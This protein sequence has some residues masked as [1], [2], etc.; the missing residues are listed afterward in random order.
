MIQTEQ[1]ERVVRQTFDGDVIGAYRHGSAVLGGLRSSSDID[2]LVVARRRMT[3]SERQTL[4]TGL[5]A[6]SGPGA[7]LGPA[8]PVE[9]AVIVEPDVRPWRYPPRCEFL[10]G[11]WLRAQ[12]LAG[13]IPPPDHSPELA[14]MITVALLG[15][16]RLF[17]PPPA[18]VLDPVP[19]RD[20]LRA[21][22][23]GVPGLL[24]NLERDIRNVILSFARIWTTLAT[25]VIRPKDQ[26]AEWALA[27]L[28]MEHRAVLSHA[29]AI[30]LEREPE[31]WSADLQQRVRPHADY[32]VG[33]IE[34]LGASY[35]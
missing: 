29:R 33:K 22:M 27:Q 18:R 19:H 10:Y 5:L 4:A 17:G 26:A 23:A 35:R 1:I 12:F 34:E 24:A 2:I 14:I 7:E 28:P 15:N 3:Q 30:Y 13:D 9:L 25:G 20:F 8:R 11:E 21:T 31:H 32:V 6:V 16:S